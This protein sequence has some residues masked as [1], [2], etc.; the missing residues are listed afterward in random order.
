M[1]FVLHMHF[2]TRARAADCRLNDLEE[3][4]DDVDVAL[5]FPEAE[6]PDSSNPKLNNGSCLHE[7]RYVDSASKIPITNNG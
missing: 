4:K 6:Q 7:S 5:Q 2:F 1:M 3:E